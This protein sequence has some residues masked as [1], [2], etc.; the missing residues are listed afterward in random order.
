[1]RVPSFYHESRRFNDSSQYINSYR[2][3]GELSGF[4]LD[5]IVDIIYSLRTRFY[6][7]FGR[8]V[9]RYEGNHVIYGSFNHFR[10]YGFHMDIQRLVYQ[11]PK[12]D[13]NPLIK[14]T[15][16]NKW[17]RCWPEM[18]SSAFQTTKPIIWMV[19]FK[20]DTHFR[21]Q[22]H[23]SCWIRLKKSIIPENFTL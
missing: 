21:L 7:L 13:F 19:L 15:K 3:F 10:S 8:A 20:S 9:V 23:E 17:S 11:N 12:A 14:L 5:N 16:S 18:R 6:I 2:L 4:S 22:Y 1:M